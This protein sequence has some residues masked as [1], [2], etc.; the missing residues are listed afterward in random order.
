MRLPTLILLIASLPALAPASIIYSNFGPGDSS[1]GPPPL[2]RA[3]VYES[4]LR[5]GPST[6]LESAW[7]D[8][9]GYPSGS[10]YLIAVDSA[11]HLLLFSGR[12]Y[13]LGI[14]GGGFQVGWRATSEPD[15]ALMVWTDN[16]GSDWTLTSTARGAFRVSGT[17]QVPEPATGAAAASTLLLIAALIRR[18]RGRVIESQSI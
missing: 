3:T 5:G 4:G 2:I 11:I 18:R 1:T 10:A 13:W 16:A 17:E 7:I 6:A 8:L 9:T 12:T 15:L 14:G